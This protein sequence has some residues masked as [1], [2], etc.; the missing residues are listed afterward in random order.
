M[1][2]ELGRLLGIALLLATPLTAHAGAILS[3]TSVTASNSFPDAVFGNP[4]NLINQGG[5]ATGYVSGVTDFDTYIAGD[6]RH[7]VISEGAEWFTNSGVP[8]ASL[9]FDLGSLMYID[10]LATWVDEFWGAGFI[11]VSAST[12]GI[13]YVGLGIFAPTDWAT[14]VTSYGA[15]VFSFGSTAARY[16]QLSLSNCPQPN[17]V[18]G[19]GCGLGE[20]AFRAGAAPVPEPGTLGLLGA[21]IML[22][23]LMKRRT[24]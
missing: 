15:D 22:V 7:T 21:A 18:A 9:T 17:S 5:L 13:G 20:V 19:G 14:N 23:G 16:V 8:S 2:K 6:P 11:G 24:A 3:A 10:G 12:D 4:N 1:H